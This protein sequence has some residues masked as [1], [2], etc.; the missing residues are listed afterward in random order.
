MAYDKRKVYFQFSFLFFQED[1]NIA[2]QNQINALHNEKQK[3]CPIK[4]KHNK[5]V[6]ISKNSLMLYH[7]TTKILEIM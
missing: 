6:Y 3:M 5:M 2:F 1:A 7:L 4:N